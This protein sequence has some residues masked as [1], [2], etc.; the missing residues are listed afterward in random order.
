[1]PDVV[2]SDSDSKKTVKAFEPGLLK[3]RTD[4]TD[5]N[6]RPVSV[7]RRTA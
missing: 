7:P 2:V 6:V 5:G 1:M 4:L 3:E